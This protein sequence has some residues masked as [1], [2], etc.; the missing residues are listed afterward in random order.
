MRYRVSS[1]AEGDLLEIFIYWADHANL[2]VADK[3]IDRVIARFRL[4]GEY[5]LA[6]QSASHIAANVRCFPAGTY[7]IY[8]RKS[9]R[10]VDILHIFHSARDQ[11]SA[12]YSSKNTR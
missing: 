10:F 5:P 1:G 8:Y 9:R 6:G 12:F 7:L 4:L 2:K 3:I 11:S